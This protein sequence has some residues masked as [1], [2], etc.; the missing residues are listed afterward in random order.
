MFPP[1]SRGRPQAVALPPS[2]RA[3]SRSE[4]GPP[5]DTGVISSCLRA[6]SDR[7]C[8][9]SIHCRLQVSLW[10]DVAPSPICCHDTAAAAAGFAFGLRPKTTDGGDWWQT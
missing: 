8:I 10:I 4:L 1:R 6:S 3:I 9:G 2:W 7:L 5:P